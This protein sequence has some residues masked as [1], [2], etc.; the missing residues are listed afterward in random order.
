[1]VWYLCVV[2]AGCDLIELRLGT[3]RED[4]VKIGLIGLHIL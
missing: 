1:M 4:R 2:V 3:G